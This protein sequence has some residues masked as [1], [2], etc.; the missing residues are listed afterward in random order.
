[1]KKTKS[2]TLAVNEM[3]NRFD[4]GL[5]KKSVVDAAKTRRQYTPAARGRLFIVMRTV[6]M[7][8]PRA[9]KSRPT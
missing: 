4:G 8:V 2:A 6:E 3:A 9:P 5:G 1:M 7:S